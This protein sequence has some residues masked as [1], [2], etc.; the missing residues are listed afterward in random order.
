VRHYRVRHASDCGFVRDIA[1]NVDYI[2]TVIFGLGC[3]F[4]RRAKVIEG[5]RKSA[6]G[7]DFGGPPPDSLGSSGY[8]SDFHEWMK[9]DLR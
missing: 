2:N 8:E 9:G 5:E 6:L 3:G 1:E 4:G 7:Q